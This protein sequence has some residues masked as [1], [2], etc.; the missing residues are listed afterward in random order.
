MN[1]SLIQLSNT[2]DLLDNCSNKLLSIM[3][4]QIDAII[5]SDAQKIESLADA[6]TS[7]SRH[8]KKNEE[9]FIKHLSELLKEVSGS[10]NEPVRLLNLKSYFP[11]WSD[12]IDRWHTI[13]SQYAEKL[14]KKHDQVIQLLE[15]AMKQNAQMMH[16]MYRQHN[17]NNSRYIS[18]GKHSDIMTGVAVNQEI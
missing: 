3:E 5:A 18:N 1:S 4:D 6:H 8:Y 13:L 17:K 7:L 11:S 16:S 12:E 9:D 2:I 10:E 15:F 14:K